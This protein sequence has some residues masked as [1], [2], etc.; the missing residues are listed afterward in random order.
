MECKTTD[1]QVGTGRSWMEI[2]HK[3]NVVAS[4]Q[5][6]APAVRPAVLCCC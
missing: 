1:L 5:S 6:K 2:R 4:M 3:T